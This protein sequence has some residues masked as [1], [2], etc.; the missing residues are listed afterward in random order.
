M[1]ARSA[2]PAGV[3]VGMCDGSVQFMSQNIDLTTY[4]ALG[5]KSGGEMVTTGAE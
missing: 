1:A 2:H 4:Q 3:V 5:T